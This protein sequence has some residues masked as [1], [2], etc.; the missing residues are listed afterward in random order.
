MYALNFAHTLSC[1]SIS[2]APV[3]CPVGRT[4]RI[5]RSPAPTCDNPSP[6]EDQTEMLRCFCPD[7]MVIKE[8]DSCVLLDDCIGEGNRLLVTF[9]SSILFQVFRLYYSTQ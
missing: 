9:C 8:D 4:P 1:D 6:A 5:S 7:G 3:D 2:S